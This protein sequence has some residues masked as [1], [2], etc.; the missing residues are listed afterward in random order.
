MA[1][2]AITQK[3]GGTKALH[4]PIH[5]SADLVHLTRRGLPASIVSSLANSLGLRPSRL[6]KMLCISE[7]TLSRR[8]AANTRLTAEESDRTVRLARVFAAAEETL[9]ST[10]LAR[11][12]LKAPNRALHGES[13]FEMLD[14]DTGVQTVESVL[15]RIAYDV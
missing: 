7:R 3:L 8:I 1:V 6:A 9:G 10:E 14:T 11:Q 15:G 5:S 2:E 13:P 4:T 12:W